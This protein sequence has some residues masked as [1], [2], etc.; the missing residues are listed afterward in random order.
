MLLF[1][2]HL[3]NS[4]SSPQ[5]LRGAAK[6][7]DKS[8]VDSVYDLNKAIVIDPNNCW[9]LKCRAYCY[10]MLKEYEEALCDLKMVIILGCADESTYINKINIMRELKNLKNSTQGGASSNTNDIKGKGKAL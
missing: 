6:G 5:Y 4:P 10:Y 2:Y 3:T 9:A 8:Y 7:L 1:S